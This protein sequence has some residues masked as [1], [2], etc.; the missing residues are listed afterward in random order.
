LPNGLY[1]SVEDVLAGLTRLFVDTLLEE[2]VRFI[3]RKTV[4]LVYVSF[5]TREG[6]LRQLAFS[7][8]LCEILGIPEKT[9]IESPGFNGTSSPDINRGMTGLYIYSNVVDKRLV[10]DA[11]VLLLRVV[12]LDARPAYKYDN[13]FVE[14]NNIQYHDV[15]SFHGRN[16]EIQIARDN[17]D[18]VTFDK[19]KVIVNLHF[20][21]IYKR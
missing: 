5:Y 10:G 19:G 4:D 20:K 14:F 16:V 11:Y 3:H 1:D 2:G 7:K 9:V 15:A 13:V 18:T 21:R 12:P 6:N 17:G 8:D